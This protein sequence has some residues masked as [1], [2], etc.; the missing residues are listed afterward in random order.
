MIPGAAPNCGAPALAQAQDSFPTSPLEKRVGCKVCWMALPKV[1]RQKQL[2]CKCNRSVLLEPNKHTWSDTHMATNTQRVF[3]LRLVLGPPARRGSNTFHTHDKD[4]MPSE[5][6]R[7]TD[8]AN[9]K[10][11]G[12][13]KTQ[14]PQSPLKF[15]FR[16]R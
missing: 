13:Y 4:R 10:R 2:K 8:Q 11:A 16:R 14:G 1:P 5:V 3:T 12:R 15:T 9:I 6:P 7:K